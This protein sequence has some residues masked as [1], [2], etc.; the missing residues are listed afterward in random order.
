MQIGNPASRHS[1]DL[2]SYVIEGPERTLIIDAGWNREECMLAMQ[3]SLRQL[4]VDLKKQ[5]FLSPTGTAI[6]SDL[7]PVSPLI[8]RASI[9]TGLMP[10]G[11]KTPPA[12]GD[13]LTSRG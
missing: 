6:T 5:T 8:P 7:S 9:S 3:A 11:S 10:N 1:L 4:G 12:G 13:F 2:N